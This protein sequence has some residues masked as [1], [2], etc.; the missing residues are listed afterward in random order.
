[1]SLSHADLRGLSRAR[2]E[3]KNRFGLA[4]LKRRLRR[5]GPRVFDCQLPISK[6]TSLLQISVELVAFPID[7]RSSMPDALAWLDNTEEVSA[8]CVDYVIR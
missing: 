8:K 1:M 2:L 3:V 4:C 5:Q 6:S 7:S